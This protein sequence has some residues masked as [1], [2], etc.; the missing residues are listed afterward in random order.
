MRIDLIKIAT[1]IAPILAL[2]FNKLYFALEFNQY[3]CVVMFVLIGL[4]VLASESFIKGS[5]KV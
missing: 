1:F 2:F 4:L 3:S 5:I